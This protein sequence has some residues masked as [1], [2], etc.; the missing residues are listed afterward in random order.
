MY[1]NLRRRFAS[2]VAGGHHLPPARIPVVHLSPGRPRYRSLVGQI[3][4]WASLYD[5]KIRHLND[6][7]AGIKPPSSPGGRNVIKAGETEDE[8]RRVEKEL[9]IAIAS[10][11]RASPGPG[12][13]PTFALCATNRGLSRQRSSI[14]FFPCQGLVFPR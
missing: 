5:C 12:H 14:R 13:T 3:A 11:R 1:D 6:L 2:K 4:Y 8:T 9:D 7:A 10:Y